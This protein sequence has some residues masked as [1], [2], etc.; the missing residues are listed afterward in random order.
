MVIRSLGIGFGFLENEFVR[1]VFSAKLALLI[2]GFLVFTTIIPTVSAQEAG[3]LTNPSAQNSSGSCG[4]PLYSCSRTDTAVIRDEH[5]PQ[6]GDNPNYYGGHSGAG[7]VAVDPA[8]GNPI[9]RV[10]DGKMLNGQSFNTSGSAEKNPWSYDETLFIGHN[11]T[12]ELCLFQ[13]DQTAFQ[14]NW[15]GCFNGYGHGGGADFGYAEA[16]N[17]AFYNY[18]LNKLQRFVIDKSDWKI[19]ADPS[20]NNGAGSFNPDA[21]NCLDGQIAAN[22]WTVHDHA[23]SSDDNTEIAAIGPEQDADPYL[24]VWNALKGCEWLNVRTW[25]VSQGWNTGLKNPVDIAWVD[26]VKPTL[27]GG[28]HNAQIDRSGAF[29]LLTIHQ[30]GLGHKFFWTLG[31]NKVDATCYKCISHWA[32]DYGV[33]FWDYQVQTSYD[34]RSQPIG[35]SAAEPNMDNGAALG[36]WNADEHLSHANAVKGAKNMYLA[37]WQTRG[38]ATATQVWEGELTG[39]SWD[40]SQRTVRFNKHWNSGFG[41]F[42]GSSRCDISHLGHYALCASDYEMNNLDKG[43]GNGL[44]QDICDHELDAAHRGTN[45]CRTDLLVFKLN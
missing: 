17:Y 13:F 3:S 27:P 41:G 26:G 35:S 23:L 22:H 34:M 39:I 40:G 9:L 15:K 6:L 25:Q 12:E 33:C 10:T 24:V 37:A 16:D 14:S 32:C 42:W 29:G 20:F 7:K 38:S 44:N 45:S 30:T 8:Y 31:S 5:P 19:T 2:V 11:E 21:S 43:F 4:P 18:V 36:E 28:I 1:A